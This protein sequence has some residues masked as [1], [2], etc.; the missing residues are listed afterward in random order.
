METPNR[1]RGYHGRLARPHVRAAALHSRFPADCAI[2]SPALAY[3]QHR[4]FKQPF[5]RVRSFSL[6]SRVS[7]DDDVASANRPSAATVPVQME[8]KELLD[9]DAVATPSATMDTLVS[10]REDTPFNQAEKKGMA[11]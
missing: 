3:A 7:A 1:D 9:D 8:E 6:S 11:K 5:K 2:R 4:V 10:P